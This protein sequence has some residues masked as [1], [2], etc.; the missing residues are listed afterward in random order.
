MH[1]DADSWAEPWKLRI[2]ITYVVTYTYYVP[3]LW[4]VILN[5]RTSNWYRIRRKEVLKINW[6]QIVV[7]SFVLFVIRTRTKDYVYY[8]TYTKLRNGKR[9]I[10]I[11]TYHNYLVIH[12]QQSNDANS[13]YIT[14]VS[15]YIPIIYSPSSF[16]TWRRNC[17]RNWNVEYCMHAILYLFRR[18]RLYNNRYIQKENFWLYI[19]VLTY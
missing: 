15:N 19:Y 3:W 16:I 11:H 17:S 4:I 9:W 7:N 12:R 6:I 10:L 8:T 18:P 2:V 13:N 14:I 1:T 5:P